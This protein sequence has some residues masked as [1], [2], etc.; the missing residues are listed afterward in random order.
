MCWV[1]NLHFLLPSVRA[2]WVGM[3][4]GWATSHK[5]GGLPS[6]NFSW[7]TTASWASL[8]TFKIRQTFII[9]KQDDRTSLRFAEAWSHQRRPNQAGIRPNETLISSIK[10]LCRKAPLTQEVPWR[11]LRH[12]SSCKQKVRNVMLCKQS[13]TSSHS[14]KNDPKKA[15]HSMKETMKCPWYVMPHTT[16]RRE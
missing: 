13:Q 11:T 8:H 12:V 5:S 9:A 1:M 2:I 14:T 6:S 16:M 10:S 7:G 4:I 3:Q 15:P